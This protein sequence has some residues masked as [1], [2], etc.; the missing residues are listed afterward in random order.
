MTYE[1]GACEESFASK[2]ELEAH[3]KELQHF[4]CWSCSI[5]FTTAQS[6]EQ[7]LRIT[8]HVAQ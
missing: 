2:E 3:K 6:L 8:G 4:K 1:C 7:H 5:G